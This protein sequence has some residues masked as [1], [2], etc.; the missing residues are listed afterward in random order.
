[1]RKR[2]GEKEELLNCRIA[3]LFECSIVRLLEEGYCHAHCGQPLAE[4]YPICVVC[5]LTTLKI[6]LDK[7][8]NNDYI[9][10]VLLSIISG[11]GIVG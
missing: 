8:D 5:R 2:E 1:M 3:P 4:G 10:K 11:E 7:N 6:I 9:F